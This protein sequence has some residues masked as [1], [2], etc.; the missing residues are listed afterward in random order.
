MEEFWPEWELHA[1][2]S[3]TI[4][5]VRDA[6]REDFSDDVQQMWRDANFGQYAVPQKVTLICKQNLKKVQW[7]KHEETW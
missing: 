3:L 1:A 4:V 2:E 5:Y 7:I 6:I